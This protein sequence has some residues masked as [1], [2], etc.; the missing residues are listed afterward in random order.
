MNVTHLK[1]RSDR[2]SIYLTIIDR[3]PDVFEQWVLVMIAAR[4]LPLA[5]SE[6]RFYFA[7]CQC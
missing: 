7:T 5:I 4:A 6:N 1:R 2:M 3:W